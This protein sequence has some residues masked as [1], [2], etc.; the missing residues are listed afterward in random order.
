MSKNSNGIDGY[1]L[2]E[3]GDGY[4]DPTQDA[5]FEKVPQPPK[6]EDAPRWDTP[7]GIG[8]GR[9]NKK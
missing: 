5:S 7:N 9:H 6:G 1:D 3:R 2:I 8:S 4:V